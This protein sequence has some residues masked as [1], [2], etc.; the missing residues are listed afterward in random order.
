VLAELDRTFRPEFLNRIDEII[1]FHSLTREHLRQIVGIQLRHLERLLAERHIT[2]E[3]SDEAQDY[4]ADRGFDPVFG[5]R[6]LKRT[7]QRELQDPLA[8]AILEGRVAEGEHVY[9][10]LA[11]EGDHLVFSA[12][13]VIPA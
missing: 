8:L 1:L 11:P 5:A 3:L 9:V 6:P 10:E 2:L 12:A 4:L 13:E 7:I